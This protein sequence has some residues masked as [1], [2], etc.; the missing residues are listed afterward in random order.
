MQMSWAGLSIDYEAEMSIDSIGAQRIGGGRVDGGDHGGRG[1]G[2]VTSHSHQPRVD[3]PRQGV[4]GGDWPGGDQDAL[5][6][7]VSLV[8][9]LF[10]EG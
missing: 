1:G 5:R 7:F 3:W 2:V 6:H 4:G 10:L 8:A 9:F